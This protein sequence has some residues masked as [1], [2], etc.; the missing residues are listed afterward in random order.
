MLKTDNIS[1][2][3]AQFSVVRSAV[4]NRSDLTANN[5]KFYVLELHEAAGKYRLFTHY[6]RVGT[7]GMREARFADDREALEREFE[8]ILREKTGPKKGYVPVDVAKAVVGSE[9]LQTQTADSYAQTRGVRCPSALHPS[10]ARFIDHIYDESKTELVRRI[11][12][13]LGAL[14][15]EQIERGTDKLR[16]LRFAIARGREDR[17]LALSSQYY[18]LVPHRF[19]RRIALEEA[20]ISSIEKADEEEELLQLMRDVFFVQGAMDAETDRK[21]RALG[22]QI[23]AMEADDPETR[24]VTRQI[25]DTQ[26]ARHGFN[27]KVGQVFRACLPDERARFDAAPGNN[28]LLFHGSRN[29]NMVG[30]LSRGLLVAPKNVP[31]SGY[32]FGKGIYFADQST[33]SAQYSGLWDDGKRGGVGYLFLA[34]VALGRIKKQRVPVYREEAPD[35]FHSVQG[36]KGLCLL[37]NEFI[38]YRREQCTIRYVAEIKKA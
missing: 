8:R 6:G 35:G 24:R 33:K 16:A 29:S 37:H 23:E 11:D 38:I 10:V 31:V 27:I 19:G 1:S 32:M 34:D 4:L 2:F 3:P 7:V 21:Y 25:L 13:P 36:C 17:I 9:A 22:A 5:N 18:S 14:T 30:I 15:R 12:T 26:S 20:A 28:R